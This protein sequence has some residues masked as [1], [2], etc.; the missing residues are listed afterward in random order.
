[1]KTIS[2]KLSNK[3]ISDAIKELSKYQESISKEAV[4]VCKTLA[5]NAKPVVDE[6]YA[7]ANV[8]PN[9]RKI[10]TYVEE[11]ENQKGAKL[12]AE[13]EGVAFIEFGAGLTAGENYPEEYKGGVDTSPGS[14]SQSEL[15]KHQFEYTNHPWWN[16]QGE[17]YDHVTPS[18]GMYQASKYIEQHADEEL[19]K[20][21]SK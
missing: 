7:M 2:I 20:A 21:F 3:G 6:A 16:Y 11:T 17:E 13:G 19:R 4:K 10:T 5:E 9:E 12:I 15:G 1:M 8:K 14:W 18:M